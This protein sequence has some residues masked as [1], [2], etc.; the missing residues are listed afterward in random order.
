LGGRSPKKKSLFW[1]KTSLSGEGKNLKGE[2][3][4]RGKKRLGKTPGKPFPGKILFYGPHHP[5][6][7]ELAKL[8][9]AQ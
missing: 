4:L 2:N 7:G 8:S 9:P 6:R 3:P 5:L 1:G